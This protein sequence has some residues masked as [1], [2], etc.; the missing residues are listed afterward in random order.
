L[1]TLNLIDRQNRIALPVFQDR[2]ESLQNVVGEV[3][4]HHSR[5]DFQFE[6]VFG[7]CPAHFE[8]VWWLSLAICLLP[9]D[10]KDSTCD[11][12]P[13]S[14]LLDSWLSPESVLEIED[15][16]EFKSFEL[17]WEIVATTC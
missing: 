10:V 7:S 3:I 13:S 12:E 15:C 17:T 8:G 16:C 2:R 4:E 6:K 1:P 11:V 9:D 14:W 5:H